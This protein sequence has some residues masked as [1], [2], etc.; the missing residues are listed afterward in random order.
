MTHLH[1]VKKIG[2]HCM[3]WPEISGG[4]VKILDRPIKS[5]TAYANYQQNILKLL[6]PP[7][8]TF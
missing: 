6:P 4:G 2:I 1:G 8:I 7:D 3:W 5:T